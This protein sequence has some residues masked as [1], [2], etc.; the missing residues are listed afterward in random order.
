MAIYED[1]DSHKEFIEQKWVEMAAVAWAGYQAEGRGAIIINGPGVKLTKGFTGGE[2][3][4]RNLPGK[5]EAFYVGEL[6]RAFKE[7][8][9]WDHLPNKK[10]GGSIA[11]M[12]RKYDP[13]THVVFVFIRRDG[14]TSIYTVTSHPLPPNAPMPPN[15][16]RA[17]SITGGI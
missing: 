5:T 10:V 8:G 12:V 7:V 13:E 9:G 2:S 4:A 16:K 3:G 11:K 17:F 15:A 14:G 1:R 6:G